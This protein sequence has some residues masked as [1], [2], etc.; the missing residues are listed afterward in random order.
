[1]ALSKKELSAQLF[2]EN[3][4]LFACPYC[5]E[6]IQLKEGRTLFC[7]NNHT[8]D[9][10]KQGYVNM[11]THA[12]KSMYDSSLFEARKRIL[13]EM[14]YEQIY[15]EIVQVLSEIGQEIT[16]LDT[17]CGE[18]THLKKIQEKFTGT[19][20]G[21]GIDIAKEGI[22]AAKNYAH[23]MWVVGDL[24]KSP[25]AKNQFD[26][27]LNI[28]SP[29]NYEEFKRISK[30]GGI[31]IKVVPQSDYLKELRMLYYANSTKED[32]SNEKIVSRFEANF[33]DVIVRHTTVTK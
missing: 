1:M 32:Y 29:A 3:T 10:A 19:L 15:E 21:S 6:S 23:L 12:V 18:G 24:A 14:F 9:L 7:E 11:L 30:E 4:Q 16:V 25:Y 28:L 33:D 8:F 5:N 26:A 22:Q 31:V 13:D 20:I 17:G 2:Q 27:I